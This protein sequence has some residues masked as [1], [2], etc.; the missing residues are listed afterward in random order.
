VSSRHIPVLTGPLCDRAA[1]YGVLAEIEAL[2]VELNH[3]GYVTPAHPAGR[4]PGPEPAHQR[5]R[6]RSSWQLRHRT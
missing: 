5:P 1:L 4:Q 6:R 3:I 2:G